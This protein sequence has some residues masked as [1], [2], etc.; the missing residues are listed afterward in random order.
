M[1][2]AEGAGVKR[3]I[4]HHTIYRSLTLTQTVDV[5]FIERIYTIKKTERIHCTEIELKGKSGFKKNGNSFRLL[6][7]S[8]TR[9]NASALQ[10]NDKIKATSRKQNLNWLVEVMKP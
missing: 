9:I 1:F 3:K 4:C 8:V 6:Q 5:H 7:V 10:L 2:K